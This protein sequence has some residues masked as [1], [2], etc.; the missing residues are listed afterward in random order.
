MRALA[1]TTPIPSNTPTTIVGHDHLQQE[2]TQQQRKHANDGGSNKQKEQKKYIGF[3]SRN[4][5][6][7]KGRIFYI[8]KEGKTD[9]I[10]DEGFEGKQ[11]V[12]W[13]GE[14]I[15]FRGGFRDTTYSY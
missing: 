12:F 2:Q 6:F 8:S 7:V 10:L 13:R 3:K 11:I 9:C 14:S 15:V 5:S 4:L 1:P